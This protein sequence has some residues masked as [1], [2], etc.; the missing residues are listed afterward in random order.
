MM[1]LLAATEA[2]CGST[3]TAT[4]QS[5]NGMAI[6]FIKGMRRPPLKLARSDQLATSGSVT[7]SNRRPT[8]VIRP[9]SVTE[10]RI[11]LCVMNWP[12]MPL[13]SPA[14]CTPVYRCTSQ[15]EMMPDSRLQPNWPTAKIQR[16]LLVMGFLVVAGVVI[17]SLLF[18]IPFVLDPST[19]LAV[20]APLRMTG[21]GFV[22]LRSG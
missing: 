4:V 16:I 22:P 3:N 13:V 11:G 2:V 12:K 15:V 20:L 17:V 5:A 9:N 1:V 6:A 14:V 21:L 7:A 19:P 18:L 10:A 8:A